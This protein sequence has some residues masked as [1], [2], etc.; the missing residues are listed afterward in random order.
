LCQGETYEALVHGLQEGFIDIGGLPK[1]VRS[2]NLS[3]A[4]FELREVGRKATKR[5]Q[6]FLD[7]FGVEYTRIQP[8]KSNENGVVEKGH[9]ILK[10]ALDQALIVR[11][12][13]DFA[14]VDDYRAFVKDVVRKLNDR[15]R[16]RFDGERPHLRPLPPT[17]FPTHTDIEVT[18]RKWSTVRVRGNVYSVP[19][20]LIGHEVTARMHPDVVEIIYNGKVLERYPRLRGAG[21][22]RID[23]HH[24][25][26]SLVTKPGA[27]ARYRFREELFP[28]L[29]FRR[30]YDALRDCRGERADVEYVRI[31]HLAAT[32]LESEVE[33][34][35]QLLLE[36]RKP[37]EYGDVSSL[38]DS[39]PRPTMGHIRPLIP[40]LS[41]FDNL[42]IGDWHAHD[43]CENQVLIAC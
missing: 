32:T 25:I 24:I 34:A 29:T 10:T 11:G 3:A 4:T 15:V 6:D 40:D 31:L 20:R 14:T 16:L 26:H 12:S 37:F 38:V 23:Y 27:F 1:V 18:V 41:H 43:K 9:H 28:S 7:H 35:L 17:R 13:R 8:G 39:T 19:S 33:T 21:Q 30:A 2:D 36:T 22:H 42:L 5:F